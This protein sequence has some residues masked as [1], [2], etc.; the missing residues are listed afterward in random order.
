MDV[1]ASAEDYNDEGLRVVDK[2]DNSVK[3][4][5]RSYKMVITRPVS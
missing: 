4:R 3:V 2:T 1:R 5:K